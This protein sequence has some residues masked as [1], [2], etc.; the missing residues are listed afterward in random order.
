MEHP[1]HNQFNNV[2]I[3]L[4]FCPN[5]KFG[6]PASNHFESID[7]HMIFLQCSICFSRWVTCTIC[8]TQTSHYITKKAINRH[9]KTACHI[10]AITEEPSTFP[11]DSTMLSLFPSISST[12]Q[13]DNMNDDPVRHHIPNT[14]VNMD[15]GTQLQPDNLFEN[16]YYSSSQRV[17][18]QNLADSG[19]DKHF[20][21]Q[22]MIANMWHEND[23]YSSSIKSH[24]IELHMLLATLFSQISSPVSNLICKLFG[25]LKQHQDLIDELPIT[26]HEV[27]S[28]YLFSG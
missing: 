4:F 17:Y 23:L 5:C 21:L 19:G 28:R 11:I 13:H 12:M 9:K 27:D 2:P 20:A 6:T 15:I 24:K 18:L 3:H 14:E 8:T 7:D 25:L 10:K 22:N 26:Y 1:L 16:E